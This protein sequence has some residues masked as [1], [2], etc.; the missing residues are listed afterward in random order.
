[1]EVNPIHYRR[2][3]TRQSFDIENTLMNNIKTVDFTPGKIDLGV[4]D[5]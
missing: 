2:L 4:Y 5:E 3:V 1:M